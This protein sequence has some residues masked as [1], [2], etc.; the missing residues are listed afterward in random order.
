MSQIEMDILNFLR[1]NDN[2]F[3]RASTTS[4]AHELRLSVNDTVPILNMLVDQQL[5]KNEPN[6][7]NTESMWILLDINN[8]KVSPIGSSLEYDFSF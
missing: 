8:N 6:W 4:I 7:N 2:L 3:G 1:Y 5:L